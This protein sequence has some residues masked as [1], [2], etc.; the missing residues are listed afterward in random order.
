[1]TERFEAEQDIARFIANARKLEDVHAYSPD[2][3]HDACGVGLV[4]AID[5]KPRREIVVRAI[6]AL[7]AVWHRGA[8]DADGKTGDGAGIHLQVPQDFFRAQVKQTGHELRSGR[9]AVGQIFLPRTDYVAQETCRTIVESEILRSGFY[10]YGWRQVP[11]NISIIGEKANATR[12]EIEQIMFDAGDS[13]DLETLDRRLYLCRRRIEKGVRAAAIQDFYIC[14]LSTR[15]LIYKGMFLAE[16]LSNFYPDLTDERFVSAFAI[17]HQRYSTNTFPTWRLAQP[18]RMLAHNGEINTLKGNANWMKNHEVKMA[19]ELF[20]ASGEDIK[21]IIQAG[22]L[23]FCGFGRGVRGAGAR[24]PRGATG[25]DHSGAGSLVETGFHHARAPPRHVRLRQ[26]HHGAMGRTGGAGRHRRALGDRRHGSQWAAPDALLRDRRR[27]A[28]RGFGNRHGGARRN[29][30]T[31]K[32]RVGPGQMIAI[33]LTDGVFYEDGAIKDRLAGEY[34]YEEWTKKI[35]DLEPIIGPGDEPRLYEKKTLR[36]RQMAAG[37]TIEDLE[38]ILHPMVEDGKEPVGS[39]GDD[40][41]LAVLSDKYR[42][43]SHY[44]RQ[45]FSQ[46]TNPPIDPLRE[47]RVM[48]LKTRFRNLGNVLVQDEKQ[49]EVSVLESPVISTGMFA[50]MKD[51]LEGRFY[52]I[53]CVFA[54]ATA[55]RGRARCSWLSSASGPRPKRRCCKATIT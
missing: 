52:E 21:P 25:E 19:S 32:G 4:A 53:D 38:V 15:S 51:H 20:G 10:L 14:S 54:C 9:I 42:P 41:P 34:P 47:E 30:V 37:Y 31:R 43:L 28:V 8:V 49:T 11:V 55:V 3:E 26:R 5:G 18:F 13:E 6:E 12:P 50:R 16:Q 27:A 22:Q 17:F 33:D 7:K 40:T 46:V 39:M 1:M 48:S 29:H 35:V 45:N 24:R 2:Q 36:R 44:F 23:R